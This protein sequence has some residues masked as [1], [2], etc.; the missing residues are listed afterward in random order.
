LVEE[1]KG[2]R[3]GR[4]VHHGE[5]NAKRKRLKADGYKKGGIIGDIM[6]YGMVGKRKGCGIWRWKDSVAGDKRQR[7]TAPQGS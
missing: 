6:I 5:G 7:S 4:V 2:E 3:V 1:R